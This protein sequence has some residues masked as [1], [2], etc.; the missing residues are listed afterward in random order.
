VAEIHPIL[1]FPTSN[2]EYCAVDHSMKKKNLHTCVKKTFSCPVFFI[3]YLLRNTANVLATF[4]NQR[5][6]EPAL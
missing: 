4:R 2:E 3:F 5:L 6:S 1:I